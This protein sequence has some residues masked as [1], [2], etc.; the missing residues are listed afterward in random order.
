MLDQMQ[1]ILIFQLVRFSCRQD[2]SLPLLKQQPLTRGVFRWMWLCVFDY[3]DVAL[4][5]PSVCTS[6][7]SSI[8]TKQQNKN[9][10]MNVHFKRAKSCWSG[11][12]VGYLLS[13][14]RIP[15]GQMHVRITIYICLGP[16]RLFVVWCCFL[17]AFSMHS[18][19]INWQYLRKLKAVSG[20]SMKTYTVWHSFQHIFFPVA[21]LLGWNK[22]KR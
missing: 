18:S 3:I 1:H 14:R 20:Y 2:A 16:N 21:C 17:C 12:V 10:Q 7:C 6:K 22:W 4:N 11:F 15:L 13:V 5:L 9:T 19:A 8:K